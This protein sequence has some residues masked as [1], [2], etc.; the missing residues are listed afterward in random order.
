MASEFWAAVRKGFW[1]MSSALN[2]RGTPRAIKEA[3]PL[4][5]AFAVGAVPGQ[6]VTN[7]WEELGH[8]TSWNYVGIHTVAKMWALASWTAYDKRKQVNKRAGALVTKGSAQDAPDEQR[9]PIPD[10]PVI[11]LLDQPNPC[12]SRMQFMYIIGTHLRL[13]GGWAIL[14]IRSKETKEPVELYPIPRAWMTLLPPTAEHPMGEY[15][16]HSPRAMTTATVYNPLASGFRVDAR[17][18]FIGGWPHPL[19]PGEQISPLSA[20]GKIIDIMEQTD[21]AVWTSLMN[22][23][24]NGM[25]FLLD[26]KAGATTDEQLARMVTKF[27]ADKTGA[28]N[29]GT[30]AV[31][32][33]VKSIERP[34]VPL[35]ELSA[36]EV[37]NQ[38]KD[39]GLGIQGVPSVA[40]GIRSEVGSYAG[41][42]A[43]FNAFAEW[44]IQPDL[45]LFAG[46][47]NNRWKRV[48]PGVELE[49]AAKRHDDPQLVNQKRDQLFAGI[50]KQAVTVN[51]WRA[52]M[53]LPPVPGGDEMQQPQPQPGMVGP[54]GQPL[55]G[56]DPAE[57]DN[58]LGL[59]LDLGDDAPDEDGPGTSPPDLSR[60]G[61]RPFSVNGRH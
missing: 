41:D 37:R 11:R 19:A 61:G 2:G 31:M 27:K 52:A 47:A 49:A 24:L 42:A 3:T 40:T 58:H 57:Q 51:E 46:C 9:T 29:A 21:N 39:F 20:C 55:P 34:T 7:K 50:E 4:Q 60:A 5:R 43:T 48:W 16:V 35:T 32:A 38:N 8:D 6:P 45:D 18:M 22:A 15:L 28:I 10:H 13:T 59:D 30:V 44:G 17:E 36:V 53:D 14:E 1:A 56:Q 12:M 23:Y 25:I 33:G 26:D 54:D